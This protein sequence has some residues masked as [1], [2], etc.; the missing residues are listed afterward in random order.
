MKEI[1]M[2]T[3]RRN[4]FS[5]FLNAAVHV[6][7]VLA[8]IRS[9]APTAAWAQGPIERVPS[10]VVALIANDPDAPQ[11]Q[12]PTLDKQPFSK[13]YISGVAFQIHWSDIQPV[14]PFL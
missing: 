6:T 3:G 9:F 2:N 11:D 4:A 10:G 14:M 1:L 5:M 13:P 8:T 12:Q 7:L